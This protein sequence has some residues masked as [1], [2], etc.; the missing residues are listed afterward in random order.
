ML[1]NV[2][3]LHPY[4]EPWYE[5]T[6]SG[7]KVIPGILARHL[8]ENVNL[9]N[10]QGNLRLY[11]EGLFSNV[12]ED[13]LKGMIK[14]KIDD[15]YVTTG[16]LN[17]A[18]KL[19]IIDESI[20][21]DVEDINR[22]E[23][24]INLRNG[25]YSIYDG[26]LLPHSPEYLSTIQ[27]NVNLDFN[28]TCPNFQA[29]L[30]EQLPE[31]AAQEALQEIMGYSFTKYTNA[32]KMFIFQG[33]SRTGKSTVINIMQEIIGVENTSNIPLQKIGDRFFIAEGF[34]KIANLYGDL[35]SAAV[36]DTGTIKS[37]TGQDEITAEK[38]NK[39]PFQYKSMAKLIFA[40][41]QLPNFINEGSDAML[42]RLEFLD[43]D[44][45]VDEN[46]IDPFLKD[47]LLKEKEGIFIWAL[48]GLVRLIGNHFKFTKS[49]GGEKIRE[50]FKLKNNSVMYFVENYCLI[51]QG[52]EMPRT[53][54]YSAYESFAF[55]HAI[56]AE[57]RI[58]FYEIFNAHYPQIRVKQKTSDKNARYLMG[59][60][61]R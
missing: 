54:L 39:D 41:N 19:W 8:I 43:F 38:K 44:I 32:E 59:I 13:K 53:D 24:F 6:K 11:K 4:T 20:Q 36:K 61:L 2:L 23:G 60:Q 1:A 42:R 45:Q 50:K 57:K 55:D 48:H 5:Q 49:V 9:I 12:S 28:A 47:R 58:R 31:K 40:T 52:Y 35:P 25:V 21:K 22:D 46:K 14:A 34:G 16:V 27:L 33:A 7:Y 3:P 26:K 51:G 17:N 29:F 15:K 56:R 10:V 18:Y 37:I 30:D